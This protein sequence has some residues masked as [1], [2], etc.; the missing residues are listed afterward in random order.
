MTSA[1]HAAHAVMLAQVTVRANA[2]AAQAGQRHAVQEL[3]LHA[4]RWAPTPRQ[5]MA[6]TSR[7]KLPLVAMPQA[8][9]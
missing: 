2:Q 9:R 6:A 8:P 3:A 1:S 5:L 4:Q 7:Q